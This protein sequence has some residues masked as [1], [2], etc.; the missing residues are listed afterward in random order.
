L[1][2][3]LATI[4][5]IA[6]TAN[7]Q[8]YASSSPD[9]QSP[10]GFGDSHSTSLIEELQQLRHSISEVKA[11]NKTVKMEQMISTLDTRV[12]RLEK[13]LEMALNSIYTLVQLQTGINSQ[14]TRFRDENNEQM[15]NILQLLTDSSP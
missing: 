15:K 13:Q 7:Q 11:T 4:H 1:V 3:H 10:L 8:M 14:V 2:A 12:G 5:H 6:P 9:R